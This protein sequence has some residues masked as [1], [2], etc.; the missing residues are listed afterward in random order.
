MV[1]QLSYT[2]WFSHGQAAVYC[3]RL[4]K[5]RALLESLGSVCKF[6][7]CL[8]E[9]SEESRFTSIVMMLGE[10]RDSSSLRPSE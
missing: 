7:L 10:S 1:P 5:R 3:V 4:L 8:S 6:G 9:R 2:I